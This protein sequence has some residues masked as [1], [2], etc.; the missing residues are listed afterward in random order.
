MLLYMENYYKKFIKYKSKYLKLLNDQYNNKLPNSNMK[1]GGPN[2][3]ND[4]EITLSRQQQQIVNIIKA[5]GNAIVTYDDLQLMDYNENS[6][7]EINLEGKEGDRRKKQEHLINFEK[8]IDF[9]NDYK[10]KIKKYREIASFDKCEFNFFKSM[11]E[12]IDNS[13]NNLNF[14]LK[15]RSNYSQENKFFIFEKVRLNLKKI[16]EMNLSENYGEFKIEGEEVNAANFYKDL[17]ILFTEIDSYLTLYSLELEP[18]SIQTTLAELEK[19]NTIKES[20]KSVMIRELNNL[21]SRNESLPKIDELIRIIKNNFRDYK[22]PRSHNIDID[23]INN[24]EFVGILDKKNEEITE[25]INNIKKIEEDYN[26][27]DIRNIIQKSIPTLSSEIIDTIVYN[28]FND[29]MTKVEITE[30][31]NALEEID[32]LSNLEEIK[33]LLLDDTLISNFEE[34]KSET[35]LNGRLTEINIDLGTTNDKLIKYITNEENLNFLN[36]DCFNACYIDN[37]IDKKLFKFIFLN[38]MFL[39]TRYMPFNLKNLVTHRS[40]SGQLKNIIDLNKFFSLPIDNLLNDLT[41][42]KNKLSVIKTIIEKFVDDQDINESLKNIMKLEFNKNINSEE[43]IE[44]KFIDS[45]VSIFKLVYSN[46]NEFYIKLNEI[47]EYGNRYVYGLRFL[48]NKYED[49]NSEIFPNYFKNEKVDLDYFFL[50]YIPNNDPYLFHENRENSKNINE[51]CKLLESVRESYIDNDNNINHVYLEIIAVLRDL[52]GK[53][54]LDSCDHKLI[55]DILN[56]YISI[57]NE[58]YYEDKIKKKFGIIEELNLN[59]LEENTKFSLDFID[60]KL[61]LK[62]DNRDIKKLVF[63]NFK[64]FIC[65]DLYKI[66]GF[67]LDDIANVIFNEQK[68]ILERLKQYILSKANFELDEQNRLKE[69]S[70]ITI[71]K[72]IKKLLLSYQNTKIEKLKNDYSDTQDNIIKNKQIIEFYFLLYD[73]PIMNPLVEDATDKLGGGEYYGHVVYSDDEDDEYYDDGDNYSDEDEELD[74]GYQLPPNDSNN[75][76]DSDDGYSFNSGNRVNNTFPP[77]SPSVQPNPTGRKT[78]KSFSFV[79]AVRNNIP[80]SYVPVVPQGES[81]PVVPQAE[82]KNESLPKPPVRRF[83]GIN[84]KETKFLIRPDITKEQTNDL[85]NS[86]YE[87]YYDDR[88]TDSYFDSL[89]IDDII[90]EIKE[91]IIENDNIVSKKYNEFFLLEDGSR[92]TTDMFKDL[93]N[94]EKIT[95]HLICFMKDNGII[96]DDQL[97]CLQKMLYSYSYYI[98]GKGIIND[99][100]FYKYDPDDFMYF[101]NRKFVNGFVKII[102]KIFSMNADEKLDNINP[103]VNFKFINNLI[104]SLESG[105]YNNYQFNKSTQNETE[106]FK[107]YT[108]YYSKYGINCKETRAA[109]D[110]QITKEEKNHKKK[111]SNV[112]YNTDIKNKYEKNYIDQSTIKKYIRYYHD[113]KQINNLQRRKELLKLVCYENEFNSKL[114]DNYLRINQNLFGISYNLSKYDSIDA[115]MFINLDKDSIRVIDDFMEELKSNELYF[116]IPE[117]KKQYDEYEKEKNKLA[118]F[119]NNIIEQNNQLIKKFEFLDNYTEETQRISNFENFNK[120]G[121][122]F[123]EISKTAEVNNEKLNEEY[124]DYEKLQSSENKKDTIYELFKNLLNPEYKPKTFFES[125]DFENFV[126]LPGF[127][128][129]NNENKNLKFCQLFFPLFSINDI[130]DFVKL[131]NVDELGI[132]LK[133]FKSLMSGFQGVNTGLYNEFIDE[134]QMMIEIINKEKINKEQMK[135]DNSTTF[136]IIN[137]RELI[138]KKFMINNTKLKLKISNSLKI[139][140][141]L[142]SN[143]SI[144][145]DLIRIMNIVI[146]TINHESTGFSRGIAEQSNINQ[147]YDIIF[148]IKDY[149]KNLIKENE[150]LEFK[151]NDMNYLIPYYNFSKIINDE[152]EIRKENNNQSW[153]VNDIKKFV[154]D[155]DIIQKI[156]NGDI[157]NDYFNNIISLPTNIKEALEISTDKIDIAKKL[158]INMNS[159]D[160]D[161]NVN[162]ST[163]IRD[164]AVTKSDFQNCYFKMLQSKYKDKEIDKEFIDSIKSR[165]TDEEYIKWY[166]NNKNLFELQSDS[167]DEFD[168]FDKKITK[169]LDESLSAIKQKIRLLNTDRRNDELSKISKELKELIESYK[170]SLLLNIESNKPHIFDLKEGTYSLH[171]DDYTKY[172]EG[173]NNLLDNNDSEPLEIDN[174]Y[175]EKN[176][177]KRKEIAKICNF[178]KEKMV[179][180]SK[181]L[182]NKFLSE[183]FFRLMVDKKEKS[184]DD[185]LRFSGKQLF[186]NSK[187]RYGNCTPLIESFFNEIKIEEIIEVK[188]EEK[189]VNDNKKEE[190]NVDE[191]ALKLAN[192]NFS[193]DSW[194]GGP[195]DSD[196]DDDWFEPMEESKEISLVMIEIKNNYYL[197]YKIVHKKGYEIINSYIRDTNGKFYKHIKY[198]SEHRFIEYLFKKS[199]YVPYLNRDKEIKSL[200]F[201]RN[202]ELVLFKDDNFDD[203]EKGPTIPNMDKDEIKREHL[204]FDVENYDNCECEKEKYKQLLPKVR[205][206]QY[207]QIIEVWNSKEINIETD[208]SSRDLNYKQSFDIIKKLIGILRNSLFQGIEKNS[209]DILKNISSSKNIV[210]GIERINQWI[211]FNKCEMNKANKYSDDEIESAKVRLKT[212]IYYNKYLYLF[213]EL[214][215]LTNKFNEFIKDKPIEEITNEVLCKI[216]KEFINNFIDIFNKYGLEIADKNKINEIINEYSKICSNTD[217]FVEQKL[218]DPVEDCRIK[219]YEKYSYSEM[220]RYLELDIIERTS[221]EENEYTILREYLKPQGDF[222]KKFT[223]KMI[224]IDSYLGSIKVDD[225]SWSAVKNSKWPMYDKV[226]KEDVVCECKNIVSNQGKNQVKNQGK[227]QVKNQGKSQG[228]SK[229]GGSMYIIDDPLDSEF[230]N[231]DNKE[232]DILYSK[233]VIDDP[234]E[235]DNYE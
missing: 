103:T 79:S 113:L 142:E 203:R 157:E 175:D 109:L 130:K 228:K 78:E 19:D 82:S 105:F 182:D 177:K 179:V 45:Y 125:V 66:K 18:N 17:N 155:Y 16:E 156:C 129:I 196:S 229:K 133:K 9:F 128:F 191:L 131:L 14:L 161:N 33:S 10:D 47:K 232:S 224:D 189:K 160:D 6:M 202:N 164:K 148:K 183:L 188:K 52:K 201:E 143:I 184:L 23:D 123:Q 84:L 141:N 104:N 22:C 121:E 152:S 207:S 211:C 25:I 21:I 119:Y 209:N 62:A 226:C 55:Y 146:S 223:D 94:R 77:A 170:K 20:K 222:N 92:K 88:Q 221:D 124:K 28:F 114:Y 73:D 181:T 163:L 231:S 61:K 174:M 97:K 205:Y 158:S 30:R 90:Y 180:K 44:S 108:E 51:C 178:Y 75:S 71:D 100:G 132:F 151:I 38:F 127:D 153:Y 199:K 65:N 7:K 144:N 110:K 5:E 149:I 135:D 137:K 117:N 140:E 99:K 198:D 29:G 57:F 213:N 169:T 42:N 70:D 230:Y 80:E 212:N 48:F 12:R 122:D 31:I 36:T 85:I 150:D 81:K 220:K 172:V 215:D 186:D 227:N 210:K 72:Y 190:M 41:K 34:F 102:R 159:L 98:S 168:K 195:N 91:K 218:K 46:I 139:K 60:R 11:S 95:Y 86:Y 134:Y 101:N 107:I 208:K 93:I 4:Q 126:N 59:S 1:G 235:S 147:I 234:Y 176:D 83:P 74:D 225:K 76:F 206:F 217:S 136:E 3:K 187:K 138:N 165:F 8:S 89:S 68:G 197:A 154:N 37:D 173:F 50:K 162:F 204:N 185:I 118:E 26:K 35:E 43:L 58:N 111:Y 106:L 214:F 96:T 32:D 145:E 15:L 192:E 24:E 166:Y 13:F 171:K 69:K 216:L 200:I 56:P 167:K 27:F 87:W 39:E 116:L 115:S 233:Y 112:N 219:L 120:V 54:K 2:D 67:Q 194:G 49:Y 40:N 53:V 64:K 63:N 193:E